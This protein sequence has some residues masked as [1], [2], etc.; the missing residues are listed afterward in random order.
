MIELFVGSFHFTLVFLS[1]LRRNCN[2][3]TFL[4]LGKLENLYCFYTS[5][6]EFS[7]YCTGQEHFHSIKFPCYLLKLSL[8]FFLP[9]FSLLL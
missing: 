7:E 2:T 9:V 5:I 1:K 8:D 6:I 4:L 3:C